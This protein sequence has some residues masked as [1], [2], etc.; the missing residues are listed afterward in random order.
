VNPQLAT[1]ITTDEDGDGLL[2][3]SLVLIYRPLDQT[4]GYSGPA[5]VSIAACTSPMSS[6]VCDEDPLAPLQDTAYHNLGSGTCLAP[7]PGTT[8]GYT[9]A[10]NSVTAPPTCYDTD[11][12]DLTL[13]LAGTPVVLQDAEIA[14]VYVGDPATSMVTGLVRGFMSEAAAAATNVDLGAFGTRR[15]SSLLRPDACGGGDDRD[16]GLDGTTRGWWFYL[17][18]TAVEVDWVGP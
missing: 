15:L 6:T 13:Y 10:P 1:N 18:F 16:Y 8:G 17:N 9:P 11:R 12:I 4:P 2:D 3:L 7:I 14:A 5:S